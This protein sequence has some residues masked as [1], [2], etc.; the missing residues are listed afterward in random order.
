MKNQFAFAAAL[1]C[2]GG[3]AF[4][5][6]GVLT[7]PGPSSPKTT[8]EPPTLP[9]PNPTP[10]VPQSPGP[11]TPQSPTPQQQA[12]AMNHLFVCQSGDQSRI[13]LRTDTSGKLYLNDPNSGENATGTYS[14]N[15]T[16][17][18]LSV[19]ALQF[20]ET[21]NRIEATK[22]LL[23]AFETSAVYCWLLGHEVGE[24]V[25]GY[26]KCPKIGYVQGIGWQENAFEFYQDHSVKWRRW[27]EYT[28]IVDTVY[29]ES[30]GTYLIEG[31][32]LSMAFGGRDKERYLT[33]V[34]GAGGSLKIS[35]LEPEKGPCVPQ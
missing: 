8:P 14:Y 33:G 19:P 32:Q 17:L 28:A 27:D 18:T 29:S 10:E 35:E 7:F 34:I 2:L 23:L 21:T 9:Q 5:A 4:A 25:Q 16:Q 30:V 31:N 22:G 12:G 24:A 3:G 15:G 13:T 20:N 6:D 1:L 11:Q 26:L